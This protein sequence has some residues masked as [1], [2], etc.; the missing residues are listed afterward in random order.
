MLVCGEVVAVTARAQAEA[1]AQA[2]VDQ[3]AEVE[4]Q[5]TLVIFTT[6]FG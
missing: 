2:G 5:R 6:D 1:D 4:P 3:F